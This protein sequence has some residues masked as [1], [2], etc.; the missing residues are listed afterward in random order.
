MNPPEGLNIQAKSVADMFI[1][2]NRELTWANIGEEMVP[3]AQNMAG[4]LDAL[5]KTIKQPDLF[6]KW[7]ERDQALIFAILMT[8]LAEAGQYRHESYGPTPGI[9]RDLRL[10]QT[11]EKDYIPLMS[12]VRQRAADVAIIYLHNQVF[13]SLRDYIDGE[14]IP[15]VNEM[16]SDCAPDRFMPFRVIHVGNVVERLFGFRIRTKDPRLTGD[17]QNDGLL[18]AIYRFKYLRF[19]TSGVRGL[20]GRDFTE[21]RAKQVVQAICDFMNKKDVPGY[22]GAEDLSGRRVVVGYDSRLN[23]QRVAEWAASVCL[24]NGFSVDLANR[25]TP[26][27]AL[28]YYL[29]DYLPEVETAGLINLTASHNPPEWQGIKFNPRQGWPAP[30]NVTD[31]IAS[32][33]NEINL[34]GSPVPSDVVEVAVE[35]GR[36][37]G[38]D[39]IDHYIHWILD[40]GK[41]N[42]RISIDAQRIRDYFFGEK[43][44]IDE[45]HGASR[46]YLAR[47][48]GEIGVQH[49]VIHAERDP[50]IPGLDYANPEEPYINQLKQKVSETGAVI[51]M[52]MDTDA[53]RYGVVDRGG[54]YLRPNQILPMLVMYLGIERGINGRVIATQTGSPLLEVLA[55]KISGNESYKPDDNVIPAYVDHVF[56]RRRVGKRENQVYQNTFMVPVGIKY[57]EEQ[58]RTDRRYKNLYPLPSDWRYTILIGGEESSGL[59]TK[60]HVTDKDGVW[61]NLLI[62]DML[63]YFGSRTEKPLKSLVAIWE[64][65]TSLSGCWKSYGGRESRGSNAGRSDVD[66][67]LEVKEDLINHYLDCFVEGKTNKLAGMDVIYAGGVRYDLVELRLRGKTQGDRHYLRIRASGTEPINRIYVESSDLDTAQRMMQNVLSKLVDLTVEKAKNA[68]SEWYLAEMLS[69]SLYSDKVLQAVKD[70]LGSSNNWTRQSL[71]EKLEVMV[72]TPGFLESRNRRMTRRWIDAL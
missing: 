52:G 10:R 35:L 64:E 46:G 66:A 58:R 44:V 41:G 26:T 31:F 59:T 24:A 50:L 51:G 36:V 13:E 43:V 71:L 72:R 61:A 21:E 33:I 2:F 8:V 3:A 1:K 16:T 40:S 15:L 47:A 68:P 32:R 48:L 39:P 23:A 55:G 11:I 18:K 42:D 29:A 27:P 69:V 49:T 67:V 45:M 38:F 53:D 20:W 14:V 37:R 4:F 17:S 70:V 60:G 57:I 30:T 5:E 6:S 7:S 65:T 28:V 34:L 25:D 62:L 22:V 12:R 63:A 19:G 56:Y 9:E 54:I